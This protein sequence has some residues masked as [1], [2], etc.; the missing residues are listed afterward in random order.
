MSEPA[1]AAAAEDK[2][3]DG[4][5][6]MRLG[7]RADHCHGA[8]ALERRD[9]GIEIVLGGDRVDDEIERARLRRHRIGI[10]RDDDMMGAELLGVRDLARRG[11]E[12]RDLG[13]ERRRELDRYVAE[14]A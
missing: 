9:E 11:G 12:D 13:P 14:P 6:R 5:G 10:A 4:G 7:R 2:R 8:V 3:H 1:N